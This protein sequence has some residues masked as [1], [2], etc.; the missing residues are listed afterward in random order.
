MTEPEARSSH[1]EEV[2]FQSAAAMTLS[3]MQATQPWTAPYSAHFEASKTYEPHRSLLHDLMH[4]TKAVG[5]L[6]SVAE[7]ADHGSIRHERV[8]Q[9]EY[10]GRIADLVM[11]AMHMAT[12]PPPGYRPF[13]VQRAVVERV[14]RVNGVPWTT[15]TCSCG[16]VAL[17]A[18]DPPRTG[19]H[20]QRS[21]ARWHP[22]SPCGSG[23]DGTD[24]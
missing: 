21:C 5:I 20:H 2:E 19:P 16:S 7:W 22:V 11:C 18:E 10:E 15:P 6:S 12:N 9:A 13:D 23:R 24:A 1:P 14:E 4:V 8:D 3:E 17:Y